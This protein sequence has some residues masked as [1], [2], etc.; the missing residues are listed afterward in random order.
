M[1]PLVQQADTAKERFSQLKQPKKILTK[2]KPQ[3]VLHQEGAQFCFVII[4]SQ[5]L[6]LLHLHFRGVSWLTSKQWHG[7]KLKSTKK[8]KERKRIWPP[9]LVRPAS[10]HFTP[11]PVT[12]PSAPFPKPSDTFFIWTISNS[13]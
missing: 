10:D 2:K 4:Q 8:K 13:P 1:L 12:L 7:N 9:A 6:I 11:L 5:E 3:H